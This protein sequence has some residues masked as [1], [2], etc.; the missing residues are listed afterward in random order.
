VK[1]FVQYLIRRLGASLVSL[2]GVALIVVTLTH[3]LPGDPARTI[4]GVLADQAEVER[5]RHQLALDRPLPMQYLQFVANLLHGHLGVS[6]RTGQPVLSEIF[7]RLPATLALAVTGTLVGSVLGVLAGVLAAVRKTTRTD[8]VVSTLSVTGVSVPIYWLGLMLIIVFAVT[9]GWLPAAGSEKPSSIILPSLAL[10]FFIMAL[11]ARMTRSTMLEVLD[12]DFVRTARAKGS[13]ERRVVY[14]HALRNAF[15]PVLTVIGLQ[16]GN[17]L[18]GAVLTESVFAWPGIGRLL[19]DSIFARDFPMVQGI[20]FVYAVL[21][22]VVNLVVDLLYTWID[23][24][25]SFHG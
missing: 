9:L 20:V 24:R 17:L 22:V 14:K 7:A 19:V 18:G 2:L 1:G 21:L 10:G 4:A 23:P 16:F 25:I 12:E 3:L 8:Y 6:A 11:V 13:S 5:M 15:I